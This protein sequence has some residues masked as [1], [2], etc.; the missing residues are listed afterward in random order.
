[1]N[2]FQTIET[3]YL[4]ASRTIEAIIVSNNDSSKLFFI[5]NHEGNSYRVF[6][7]LM[8]LANFFQD[9]AE[10]DF[11]FSSEME[12]DCFFSEVKLPK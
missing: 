6:Q 1:M 11:N 9:K 7:N 3:E 12:L 4:R 2:N 8:N 5:Y 10:A